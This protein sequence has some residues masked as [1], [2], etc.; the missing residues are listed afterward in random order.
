MSTCTGCGK[1]LGSKS[2]SRCGACSKSATAAARAA[3]HV[4]RRVHVH[5]AED[6]T[7]SIRDGVVCACEEGAA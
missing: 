1:T 6:G 2:A 7:R 5:V 3:T 4:Y